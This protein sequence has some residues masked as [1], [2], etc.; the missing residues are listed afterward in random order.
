[1]VYLPENEAAWA[2]V[3]FRL[4]WGRNERTGETYCSTD[5]SYFEQCLQE[6]TTVYILKPCREIAKCLQG[7]KLVK[8]LLKYFE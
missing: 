2:I 7:G 6:K 3:N 5:V 4:K 1:M 8:K